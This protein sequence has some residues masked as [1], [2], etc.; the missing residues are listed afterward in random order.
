MDHE[1]CITFQEALLYLKRAA[2]GSL[3]LFKVILFLRIPTSSII[4]LA[5]S[6]IK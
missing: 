6:W 1:N 5:G 4:I 3:F 2:Y